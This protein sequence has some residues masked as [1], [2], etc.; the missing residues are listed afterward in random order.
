MT[1]LNKSDIIS[2]FDKSACNWDKEMIKD[3]DVVNLILDKA[4][5]KENLEILDVACGTGVLF[6]NYLERKVKSITAIDISP[7]MV[8]IAKKNYTQANIDIICGDVE[9]YKFNKQFDSIM[10]YNAFPHFPNPESLISSLSMLLKPKGSLT[11]AHGMSKKQIDHIHNEHAS[12][13]S[14]ELMNNTELEKLMKK[15]LKVTIS[16]SDDK[17][18]QV[19]GLKD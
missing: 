6:N 2:F 14:I 12:L 15:Y 13:V 1:G 4:N 17:M 10:I 8:N 9:E 3:E 18:Y 5:I 16:I 7:E 19:T 11:I